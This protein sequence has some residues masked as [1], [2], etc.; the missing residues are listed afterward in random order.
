MPPPPGHDILFFDRQ[1]G[2]IPVSLL[3]HTFPPEKNA[4]RKS[5]HTIYKIAVCPCLH[6]RHTLCTDKR[7]STR[8]IV[9]NPRQR[10]NRIRKKSSP[11]LHPESMTTLPESQDTFI[12]KRQKTKKSPSFPFARRNPRCRSG[13]PIAGRIVL[14]RQTSSGHL[15]PLVFHPL[16]T[17]SENRPA[18][19]TV[20]PPF[21][22]YRPE[23]RRRTTCHA[24]HRRAIMAY[25]PTPQHAVAPPFP[26]QKNAS[27]TA[28]PGNLKNPHIIYGNFPVRGIFPVRD[29]PFHVKWQKFLCFV[30][31]KAENTLSRGQA[32]LSWRP[33][34][35]CQQ[36]PQQVCRKT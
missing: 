11:P 29:C 10:K 5:A 7:H 14:S 32:L 19:K 34:P 15:S 6:N 3:N 22:K 33:F 35:T 2:K 36:H 8:C 17:V 30:T 13:S 9:T 24:K 4:G 26:P 27:R 25:N 31:R 1:T 18:A 21:P 16:Q 12:R 23:T 28:R 20:H